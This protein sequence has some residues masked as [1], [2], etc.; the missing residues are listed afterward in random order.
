MRWIAAVALCLVLGTHAAIAPAQALDTP[1][2]GEADALLRSGKA[3]E[4]WTLLAPLEREYAGRPDY[5]YLLGLAALESGRPN[6]AT[7]VLERVIMLNPGHLAARLEMARAYFALDDFERAEREFTFIVQS[8]APPE[9]RDLSHAYLERMRPGARR[10]Q[11]GLSGYAEVAFGYDTNVS[12]AARTSS[13]FVPALG[14]ELTPDPAFQ[15][16]PDE[17]IALA[18]GMEYAHAL[19]PRLAIVAGAD[20]LQRWHADAE[21]FD[22][23]S[24]DVYALLN[25][26]LDER[27]GMQYSL[28]HE[29][30]RLDDRPYREMQSLGAQWSRIA[31]LRTRIALGA[32]GHRVRYRAPEVHEASSDLVAVSASASYLLQPAS[33][34]SAFGGL[35]AGYDNAVAGRADGDRRILGWSLGLQRRLLT[36]VDGFARMSLLESD[37]KTMNPSFGVRRRDDQREGVLGA[38]WEFARGWVLRAQVL[39]TNNRSNVPLNDYERTES[40]IA[41]QRIWD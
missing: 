14:V 3:E 2:L 23:R 6:R 33:L 32:Q 11:T 17:F 1:V 5:D 18:A 30:Y 40:S 41:L 9:I 8:G 7:F 31:S 26:R 34:T 28:R 20:V 29:D 21:T 10:A 39:R 4:A 24:V 25:H 15:R 16:Q 13:V 36:R 22:W 19:A 38:G 35:Y 12:A 27:D 37:Y